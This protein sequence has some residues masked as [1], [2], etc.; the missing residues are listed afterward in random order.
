MFSPEID[1][2]VI[3]TSWYDKRSFLSVLPARVIIKAH[4]EIRWNIFQKIRLFKKF[5]KN[6]TSKLRRIQMQMTILYTC[7]LRRLT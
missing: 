7:H 3:I 6:L 4:A 5:F 1:Y 2:V